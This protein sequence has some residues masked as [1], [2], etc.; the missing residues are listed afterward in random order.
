MK[1]ILC[2]NLF[3]IDWLDRFLSL[4]IEKYLFVLT[5]LFANELVE[6]CAFFDSPRC[7]SCTND[8]TVFWNYN[9]ESKIFNVIYT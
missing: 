3:I 9:K 7:I 2:R 5:Q 4:S 8:C 1:K 6:F